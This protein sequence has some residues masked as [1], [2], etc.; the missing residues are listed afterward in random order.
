MSCPKCS[1]WAV[2]KYYNTS[3]IFIAVQGTTKSMNLQLSVGYRNKLVRIVGIHITGGDKDNHYT[4]VETV[5]FRKHFYIIKNMCYSNQGLLQYRDC[6][7]RFT[8]K[9]A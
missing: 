1:I 5:F 8:V 9:L 2:P 3:Y 4:P 6:K 7:L